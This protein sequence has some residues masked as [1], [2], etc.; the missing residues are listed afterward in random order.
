MPLYIYPER[1]DGVQRER[2][3]AVQ[4]RL[5]LGLYAG[6]CSMMFSRASE[7]T[8]QG[9]HSARQPYVCVWFQTLI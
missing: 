4:V 7:Y 1:R 8:A 6:Y 5:L 3:S 2:F 9:I